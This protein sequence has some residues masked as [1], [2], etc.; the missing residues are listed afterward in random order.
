MRKIIKLFILILI[1][2]FSIA[3]FL[4]EYNTTYNTCDHLLSKLNFKVWAHRGYYENTLFKP[5]SIESF[6]NAKENNARGTE[7]DV[8]YDVKY[9]KFVVSHNFPYQK[10]DYKV[11]FLDSVFVKFG[12]QFKYWLDF[13]NLR[14]LNEEKAIESC[15]ELENLLIKTKVEKHNILIESQSLYNLNFYTMKGFYTSWW[16]R[17]IKS[18]YKSI[19]TNYKYKIYY[20][21][22]KYSS[23]SMP[24]NKFNTNFEN[25][26]NNI[27]INLFT[28][29]EEVLFEDYLKNKKIK[30]IL[31][32]KKWFDKE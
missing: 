13:K 10:H 25:S 4:I 24:Y 11:L 19:V 5:N 27:P 1:S 22:G 21:L 3:L 28:V 31:T 26:M 2:L 18:K 6:H 12:N 8:F 17:P 32:D 14:N 20:V 16:I 7:L 23:L 15:V 29:N 9:Q 30:I